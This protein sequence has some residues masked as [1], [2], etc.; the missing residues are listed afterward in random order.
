VDTLLA[1]TAGGI[2]SSGDASTAYGVATWLSFTGREAEAVAIWR[3]MVASGQ[4]GGF[5]TIA[6]EAELARRGVRGR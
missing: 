3:R 5:G 2:G 4:W 1:A 6:A